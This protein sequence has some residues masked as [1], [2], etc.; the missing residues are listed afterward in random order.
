[1]M[2]IGKTANWYYVIA[3]S[4]VLKTVDEFVRMREITPCVKVALK[5]LI[6]VVLV[7]VGIP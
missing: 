3:Y 5:C 6:A 1:M 4:A 2:L 7:D